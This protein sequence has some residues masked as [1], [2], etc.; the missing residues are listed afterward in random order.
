M[1]KKK[2][3]SIN[4]LKSSKNEIFEKFIDWA[5][6][7]GRLL[8]II[9]EIV[10]L[11]AF[12]YRFSLDRQLIDLH[13]KI[14]QEEAIVSFFKKKEET[15]RNLQDRIKIASTYSIKSE[16]KVKMSQDVISLAPQG[17]TFNEIT[18]SD[19]LINVAANFQAASSLKAFVE[20]LRNYKPVKSVSITQIE[21]RL[22]SAQILVT[23]TANLNNKK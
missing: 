5:L 2:S 9:T 15:Y 14:K 19:N 17:M 7:V 20:S 11:S 18:I 1:P 8:V 12:I 16:E 6:T 3:A 13:G 21:N 10:A 23:I 22:S 4:L